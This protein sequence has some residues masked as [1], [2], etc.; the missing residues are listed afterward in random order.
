MTNNLYSEDML[1]G[2]GASLVSPAV[3]ALAAEDAP[4]PCAILLAGAGSFEQ[5]HVTMTRGLFLGDGE[6]VADTLLDRS[7]EIGGRDQDTV[8]ARGEAQISMKWPLAPR[9]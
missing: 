7:A 1:A 3:V 8:P 5:A 9:K 4:R 6:T 2:L